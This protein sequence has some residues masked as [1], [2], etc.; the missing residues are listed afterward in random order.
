MFARGSFRCF[1]LFLLLQVSLFCVHTCKYVPFI[2]F[3]CPWSVPHIGVWLKLDPVECEVR[4]TTEEHQRQSKKSV[5]MARM[6][7]LR[8]LRGH[9]CHLNA[10]QAT[11]AVSEGGV[12]DKGNNKGQGLKEIRDLPQVVHRYWFRFYRRDWINI[13]LLINGPYS[14]FGRILYKNWGTFVVIVEWHL[15]RRQNVQLIYIDICTENTLNILS[16]KQK[17]KIKTT[18]IHNVR[19]KLAFHI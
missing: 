5:R 12:G 9:R 11:V 3:K 16:M 6:T 19:D 8:G 14:W 15:S 10:V 2:R 4:M 7:S 13:G 17:M 1:F 18:T